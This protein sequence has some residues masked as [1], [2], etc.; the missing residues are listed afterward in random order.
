MK[1]KHYLA[2]ALIAGFSPVAFAQSHVEG[3]EYYRADQFSNAKELLQRNYNNPGTDKSVSEYYLGLISLQEGNSAEAKT[4]FDKGVS[5]NPEYAY[6]YVGLGELALKN[7]QKKEAENYFKEA[8]SRV[9]KDKNDKASL[10]IA[11][12]RAYYNADPTLY[13][14]EIDKNV[15][16]AQKDS[17]KQ[18]PAYTNADIY[19][20]EGDRKKD[21]KDFGGAGNQYEMATTYNPNATEAYVKY[22]ELF[23]DVNPQYAI[24]MLNNL[25]SVNPESALGQRELAKAYLNAKQYKEASNQYRKYVNNPNHF[26]QDENQLSYLLFV[27][28]DYQDGYDFASNLLKQNPND[29]TAQR[30]QFMNAAQLPN[31]KDQLVPLAEALVVA[32][33]ANPENK[34]APIDYNL[35]SDELASNGKQGEAEELLNEAISNDPT[36]R[37]YYKQLA[38]VY[39][40]DQNLAK[41]ADTFQGYIDNSENPGYNDYLQ[42]ATYAFYGGEQKRSE[43][44]IDAANGFY[45]K[46]NDAADKALAITKQYP[47]P[48]KIKG[49]IA[50]QTAPAEEVNSAA[51]PLYTEG[52]AIFEALPEQDRTRYNS[53]AKEMY[54]YMGNYYLDQKDLDTALIYFNKFLEIDPNNEGYRKFVEGLTK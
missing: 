12:A 50:K 48:V 32:H 42:L 27:G 15:L 40:K 30:F 51:V 7:G 24:K 17:P 2:A 31:L 44:D 46:S 18:G 34:F 13:A 47:K 49:D 41:A 4:H 9:G 21:L 43:N 20:F 16:Q 26:K 37:D 53:D 8:K 19:L 28:G 29:F 6:N 45:Q 1:L 14:K 54:N 10:D 3:M 38:L 25:L 5:I 23:T 22:A 35:I 36:N 39:V 33:K 52:L 11:I